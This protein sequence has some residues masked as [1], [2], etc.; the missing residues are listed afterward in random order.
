MLSGIGYTRLLDAIEGALEEVKGHQQSR[1]AKFLVAL[2]AAGFDV[3]ELEGGPVKAQETL[4]L[5]PP[6]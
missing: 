4:P 2:H 1:P 5:D 6:V 3:T